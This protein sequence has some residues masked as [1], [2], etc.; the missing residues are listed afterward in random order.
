MISLKNNE[1][2]PYITSSL[3]DSIYGREYTLDL[4]LIGDSYH[5]IDDVIV[6]IVNKY[7]LLENKISKVNLYVSNYSNSSFVDI[8]DQIE[9]RQ[10]QSDNISYANIYPMNQ[11]SKIEMFK[12]KLLLI[13]EGLERFGI[14]YSVIYNPLGWFPDGASTTLKLNSD[15]TELCIHSAKNKALYQERYNKEMPV[16]R[17]TMNV[18]VRDY[19]ELIEFLKEQ[20]YDDVYE[21]KYMVK[22]LRDEI[23]FGLALNFKL[24]MYHNNLVNDFLY[25]INTI[26]EFSYPFADFLV[27]HSIDEDQNE[28][29]ISRNDEYSFSLDERIHYYADKYK[30][31][32]DKIDIMLI[33]N[34]SYDFK[35]QMI[36]D[37]V[38]NTND[39][40]LKQRKFFSDMSLLRSIR[41]ISINSSPISNEIS[42]LRNN[43]FFLY[44]T[45][46]GVSKSRIYSDI[47]NTFL[48]EY[49]LQNIIYTDENIITLLK[50]REQYFFETKEVKKI[51]IN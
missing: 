47:R 49:F 31:P 29:T 27:I 41:K 2:I 50:P 42:F 1:V 25:T 23:E 48:D 19:P 21:F 26:S 15:T 34:S 24:T 18:D 40:K 7:R 30:Y 32:Y 9:V 10:V 14:A 37:N 8:S 4:N 36:D 46:V 11:S 20:L 17:D 44:T 12:S 3:P 43:Y 33:S 39:E 28:K 45:P 35:L 13:L 16:I 22:S 6:K 5:T 38:L 51:D